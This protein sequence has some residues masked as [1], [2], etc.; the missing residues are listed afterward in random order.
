MSELSNASKAIQIGCIG[1]GNMARA[2]LGG[3]LASGMQ[4]DQ[5][6]VAEP[7][8]DARATLAHL[9]GHVTADNRALA[10]R[11][12]VWVL[13][14]KPQ[15]LRPVC[16]ALVDIADTVQPLVISIAAGITTDL[17]QRWLGQG[18]RIVR[19]MPNTPALINAGATGLFAQAKVAAKER[20]LVDRLMRAVG[21]L[22]WIADEA[23]MDTVTATSGS[24]PAYFFLLME[25][26]QRAAVAQGLSHEAA[27]AL[28]LNTALGA[29]KMAAQ[30]SASIASLR[31]SVTS[32]GGTTE[33][34]L[35]RF[36]DGH[37]DALV[38]DA[39]QAACSRGR[40]LAQQFGE[41]A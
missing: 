38:A 41:G 40:A 1:G 21:Q 32:P 4:M 26:M 28:V 16:E 37:F 17:L 10:A 14:V 8:A 7:N 39:M 20:E 3:W 27:R 5:L 11:S 18:A 13:A 30:S 35:E 12:Q 29:A 24:G 33:A 23:L 25:S 2:L 19:A 34:A 9:A 36:A 15:V 31:E 6:S 22:A